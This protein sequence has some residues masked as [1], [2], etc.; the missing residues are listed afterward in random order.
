VLNLSASANNSQAISALCAKILLIIFGGCAIKGGMS[1]LTTSQT[2][3]RLNVGASTVRLWCKQGKFP[4]AR[5]QDTPRGSVW[6]IPEND[7]KDFDK[8]KR[9]RVPK[10]KAEEAPATATDGAT[11]RAA[12]KGGGNNGSNGANGQTGG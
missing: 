9:G 4:N 3:E 12:K 6:L 1:E 7:V 5:A 2:A 8:P 11:P 10:A